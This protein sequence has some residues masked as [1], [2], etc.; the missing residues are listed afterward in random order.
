M[1][2]LLHER[3]YYYSS[4]VQLSVEVLFQNIINLQRCRQFL[5]YTTV[6]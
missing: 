2:Y 5:H 1:Y 3:V 6:W 4:N